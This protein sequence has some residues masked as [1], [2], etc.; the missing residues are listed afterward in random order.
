MNT[1]A[2]DDSIKEY[3]RLLMASKKQKNVKKKNRYDAVLLYIE[4]YSRKQIS[5]I[6]HIPHRTVSS[7]IAKYEGGGMEAFLL[8]KQPGAPQKFSEEQ[9]AKL[10]SVI[11]TRTRKRQA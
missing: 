3:F 10:L 5:E 7:H 11:S 1:K 4:G 6:L 8:I 2:I 9:E